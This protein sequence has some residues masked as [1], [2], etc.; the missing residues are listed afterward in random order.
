MRWLITGGCGFVGSNVADACL[1]R[2]YDVVILDNLSRVGSKQNLSWLRMRHGSN[3]R[4]VEGDIRN[5]DLVTDLIQKY[6]PQIIAHLAG[7][8][9]M[10]TSLSN[11]RLD[12]E[13]NAL[14]SLN[15]LEAV[16]LHSPE[17]IVLYSSTNKVYGDLEWI[18]Y[19][20]TTTRYIAPDF[21]AGFD[22]SLPLCFASPYG[23]SKGSAD[24][25]MLDYARIFGVRTIVFRHSSIYGGRQFATFDQGW[26][27]W[28][29]VQALETVRKRDHTFTIA[30]NGKQVRDVLHADDLVRLYVDCAPACIDVA[31]GQAF[32]IGGSMTQSLSILELL[33]HL[34]QMLSVQ[35][36]PRHLPPRASDQKVFVAN[37]AKATRILGWVPQINTSTGLQQMLAWLEESL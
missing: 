6:R 17:T 14:G 1:S 34:E 33:M 36:H 31:A 21:P 30:G 32:N 8:V 26:V 29:C 2:G 9:A 28:F 3:W 7:Q 35:L 5:A 10:T 20:E 12:F 25:Y 27:G 23:C 15:V 37:N 4:M 22:E 16:R 18:D 19:K 24:Q 13:I 11:P